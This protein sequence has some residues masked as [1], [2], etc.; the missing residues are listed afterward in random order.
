[1]IPFWKVSEFDLSTFQSVHFPLNIGLYSQLNIKKTPCI[2]GFKLDFFLK[3]T[4]GDP[5]YIG[6]NGIEIFN[7]SG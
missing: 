6:L 3:T 1:M 7:K 4:F 2:Q 5:F